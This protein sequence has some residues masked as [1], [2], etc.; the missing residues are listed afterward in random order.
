M[1][2]AKLS[3]WLEKNLKYAVKGDNGQVKLDSGETAEVDLE[4]DCVVLYTRDANENPVYHAR[5]RLVPDD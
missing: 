2:N 1:S 4:D 3:A 5:V